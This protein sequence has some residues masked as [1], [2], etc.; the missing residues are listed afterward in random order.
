M[1][2]PRQ[3]LAPLD[4]EIRDKLAA[5]SAPSVV[6]TLYRMG[7]QN[8]LMRRAARL[9]PSGP[10]MVGV[11]YTMRTVPIREDWRREIDSGARPNLQVAAF[12]STPPGAV[13]VCDAGGETETALL[14]DMVSTHFEAKGVAG[15]VVDG[16]VNDAAAIAGLGLPVYAT[17]TSTRPFTSHRYVVELNVAIGCGGVAVAPGDV[18]VGDANGVA[19]IPRAQVAEVADAALEREQLEAFAAQL[20]R[21]G[22]PLK[23][24]YPPDEATRR[25][26]DAQR[27]DKGS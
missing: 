26:F 3:T 23:G 6:S 15:V 14:G 1:T 7:F 24:V 11:A 19:V 10:V 9:N 16:A 12:E 8:T 4:A 27:G 25:R 13:L 18:L 21:E 22:A 20:L 5:S 2:E 17:G